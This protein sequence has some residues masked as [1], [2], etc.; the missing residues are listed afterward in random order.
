MKSNLFVKTLGLAVILSL[1]LAVPAFTQELPKPGTI[2]DKS[3]YK[4]YAHLFPPELLPAFEDGWGGL[5][6]PASIQVGSQVYHL[7][8]AFV[9]MSAKNK[10]KY[11]L[12]ANGNLIGG[13]NRNGFPF[14]DLQSSDKDF[15]TKL[16][17][18]YAGKYLMDDRQYTNNLSFVQRRG[19]PVRCSTMDTMQLN[20]VNRIVVPPTPIMKTD[21][22]AAYTQIWHFKQPE[23]VKNTMTLGIRYMDLKKPDETYIYLPTQRR[24]LRGDSSQRSVPITSSLV[25]LDDVTLFDGKTNEFTYKLVREEKTLVFTDA[26]KNHPTVT[27][28]DKDRRLPLSYRG[29]LSLVDTY[30]ID[31]LAKDPLYP[32]SKKRIWVSKDTLHAY[33]AIVWD[34]AGKLWKIFAFEANPVPI[35]GDD[36]APAESEAFAVDLQFGMTNLIVMSR[37]YNTGNLTWD[38]LSPSS[39]V[40]RAR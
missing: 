15:L 32:Q 27:T 4:K 34:R 21:Q 31:I 35:P 36:P 12:D 3:N 18:N 7:P 14:P 6:K 11:S 25:A 20:Y 10:G 26:T 23:A 40:K 9:A 2:I 17:W 13:W 33:Y 19:E 8:K 30:V 16:M 29:I 39:L 28:F 24:V 1:F 38:D 5:I 37:K 22:N